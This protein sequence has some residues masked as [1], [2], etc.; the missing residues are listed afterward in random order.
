MNE[1]DEANYSVANLL[2]S[3]PSLLICDRWDL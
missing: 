2:E 3:N 1:R